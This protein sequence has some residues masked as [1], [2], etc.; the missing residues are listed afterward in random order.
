M[1]NSKVNYE[2]VFLSL[3]LTVAICLWLYSK[4]PACIQPIPVQTEVHPTIQII[5][6]P[7]SYAA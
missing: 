2:Q 6:F 3:I 1:A 7:H 5:H 4:I